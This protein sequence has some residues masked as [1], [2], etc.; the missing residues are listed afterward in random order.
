MGQQPNIII[1]TDRQR[2]D[3]CSHEGYP[4]EATPTLDDLATTLGLRF[5]QAYT[6]PL[7]ACLPGVVY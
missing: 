1:M 4:L 3:F 7:F 2:P 5:G 6:P